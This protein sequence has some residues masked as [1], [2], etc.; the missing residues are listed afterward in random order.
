M[1]RL[2]KRRA[3]EKFAAVVLVAR[4]EV[5]RGRSMAGYPDTV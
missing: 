3:D 1:L 2:L 5:R 4:E